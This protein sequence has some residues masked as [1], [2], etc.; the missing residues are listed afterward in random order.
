VKPRLRL[1]GGIALAAAGLILAAAA[2]PR[3]DREP[4]QVPPR[5]SGQRQAR[6]ILVK[7]KPGAAR[8]AGLPGAGA[9]GVLGA[10]RMPVPAGK[11]AR[12]WAAAWSREPSVAWA[13]PNYWRYALAEEVVPNDPYYLPQ[14][15]ERRYQQW[16]LPRINANYA[17]SLSEGNAALV[18]A[19]VDTGV[20]LDHPDLKDRLLPGVSLVHQDNYTPPSDGR[21]DNGHGTHVAGIITAATNNAVGVAGCSWTGKVIPVKVL[22]RDGEGQDADIAEG[23]YW[24]VNAGA[25]II[26]LS[27]GGPSEDGGA[28]PALQAAVDYAYTHGCLVVAAA[29]NSGDNTLFYPA[30]LNHVLAVAATDP[31]DARASYSSYGPYVGVSAPGGSGEEAFNKD[32]GILSTYWDENS[33]ITDFMGGPEAGEYAVSAGTSMAAALVSGAAQVL[34]ARDLNLTADQVQDLLKTTALDIGPPGTDQETGAGRIDLLSALGNPPVVRPE[35]TLYNYPNPFR[36]GRDGATNIVFLLES[37]AEGWVRIY[38]VSRDLV[39]ERHF[40]ASETMAGKN[41]VAWDG[42]NGVG[43]NVANGAYYLRVTLKDGRGSRTQVI[44]VLHE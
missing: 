42:R 32:T 36:P 39:W 23:I 22:N 11:T 29:G 19:V 12:A 1:F 31:W 2:A 20:D 6:E 10:Y 5:L 34:W 4:L 38:D 21:D 30:A 16:H 17:W 25:R 14:R 28:P 18:V 27:L 24:A 26:N 33:F 43:D 13:Q 40:N 37:P 35:L 9:A 41:Y 15:N 8:P 44:A 3:P 7:L